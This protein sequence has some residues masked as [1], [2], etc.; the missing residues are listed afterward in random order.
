VSI[1]VTT[2]ISAGLDGK[3]LVHG[4]VVPFFKKNRVRRIID[5]GAG[6]LRHTLELLGAGFEVCAVEFAQA[7]ERPVCATAL[8]EAR[9]SPN[10]SA[11]VW[12]HDYLGDTARFDAAILS[13]VLQAMPVPAE[14]ALVLKS[15]KKKLKDVSFLLYMSRVNQGAATISRN[16][17]VS[18]GFFM[19]PKREVHSFYREF[20]TA[21]THSTFEDAGFEYIRCLSK[22][23][24]EQVFLYAKGTGAWA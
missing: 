16:Q 9:R 15:L 21:E 8:S 10:C 4:E 6:A 1:D 20:T 24:T 22:R 13:Y 18:D 5:F 14:R 11:L 2:S 7:F 12:P 19:W 17:R 3:A 23:G